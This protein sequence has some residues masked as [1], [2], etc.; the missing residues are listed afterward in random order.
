MFDELAK[1]SHCSLHKNYLASWFGA[2]TRCFFQELAVPSFDATARAME[3]ALGRREEVPVDRN[4]GEV[5]NLESP[6]QAENLTRQDGK[7]PLYAPV[8]PGL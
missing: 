1:V 2:T 5:W 3:M 6:M 7:G 4:V 8:I